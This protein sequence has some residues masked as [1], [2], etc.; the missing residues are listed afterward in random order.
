MV[1][2]YDLAIEQLELVL[3]NPA[4][5]SKWDAKLD[6]SFDPLREHPRFQALLEK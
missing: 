5:Y 4:P 1:G 3:S 2:E 6:P